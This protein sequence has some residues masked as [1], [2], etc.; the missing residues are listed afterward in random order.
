MPD[1]DVKKPERFADL[2]PGVKPLDGSGEGK[3]NSDEATVVVTADVRV[4]KVSLESD[5]LPPYSEQNRESA[6]EY[7]SREHELHRLPS[8]SDKEIKRLRQS[9]P[10]RKIDLHSYNAEEAHRELE[11]FLG[12]A[13]HD[14]IRKVEVCH[15]IGH[16]SPSESRGIL[17]GLTR[18]WL[19]SSTFV[20]AY[21]TPEKNRGMVMVLLRKSGKG[22][23]HQKP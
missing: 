4:G 3:P 20:L 12:S 16:H 23:S 21:V 7:T 8:I 22:A 19:Q 13:I 5:I 18:Y 6:L 10:E 14:G 17:K 2:V 11:R 15:G 9:K 1:N